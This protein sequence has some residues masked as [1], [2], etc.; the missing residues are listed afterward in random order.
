MIRIVND[1][2]AL[3]QK[4]NIT[5]ADILLI[6]INING[7]NVEI[8]A[9]RVRFNVNFFFGKKERYF[10]ALQ[11]RK[12]SK[13]LIKN[14]ILYLNEKC[15]GKVENF[16]IDFCDTFYMRRN[17]TVLNINPKSRINCQGCKFCYTSHQKFRSM[18]DL[19][20]KENLDN[21][22]N[23]WMTT[24]KVKDLNGLYKIAVVSGCFPSEKHVIDFLLELNEKTSKL[25]FNGE[26]FYL[27]SQIQ[28][29]SSLE[30]LAVI[31]KFAYC[32][33]LE[34]F[35]NRDYFLKNSKSKF[36][37]EQIK[38]VMK[39]S[40]ELGFR[41]NYTYIV[42]LEDLER[43]KLGFMDFLKYT[44]SFPI[45]NIFQEHQYQ[46]GMRSNEALKIEFY[47]KARKIIEEIYL[48]TTMRPQTWEVCRTLWYTTFGSERLV[49]IT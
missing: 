1:L 43:M 20:V 5:Y 28:T 4:F 16:E 21:F 2:F 24:Y 6:D 19:T 37:I 44:N 31:P 29:C 3:S 23:D 22:L 13:Y 40:V 27:G 26:I 8:D 30:K 25:N 14:G 46:V 48:D 35:N 38:D 9:D 45:I 7:I 36:N 42:G 34:C 49:T 10:C 12:D 15:I 41:T 17:D 18:I 39:K 11:V 47:L 33:T 32:L